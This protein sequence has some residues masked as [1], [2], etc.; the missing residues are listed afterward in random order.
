M[1]DREVFL[2]PWQPTNQMMRHPRDNGFASSSARC[3]N[4]ARPTGHSEEENRRSRHNISGGPT[5]KWLNKVF[6]ERQ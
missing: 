2:L 1:C 3:A 6:Q 5:D 4:A